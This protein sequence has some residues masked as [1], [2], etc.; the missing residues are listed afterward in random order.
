MTP[1]VVIFWQE[2]AKTKKLIGK[3]NMKEYCNKDIVVYWYPEQCSHPGICLRT[4]PEV[5]CTEKRPWVNVDGAEPEEIIKCIDKCPS[6]ALRYSLPESSLVNPELAK[7]AGSIENMKDI[8]NAVKIKVVKKGPYLVE[9]PTEVVSSDGT[10][11]YSG[12]RLALCSCGCTQNP[13]FCDGS[14]RK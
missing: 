11:I 14:H 3:W 6:G 4:L 12:A 2:T 1:F 13:P 9:G 8:P 7:G 10:P 5:F